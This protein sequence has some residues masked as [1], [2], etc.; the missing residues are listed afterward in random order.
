M[1]F[2]LALVS[3]L[4]CAALS[5]PALAQQ[6]PNPLIVAADV[7]PDAQ[8]FDIPYGTPIS[9]DAA[10][11]V[12]QAAVAE[13]KKRNWKMNIA[14]M[15]SGANLVAFER[16]DGAQLASITISQD[17]AR[18]AALFRRETKVFETTV[19]NGNSGVLSLGPVVASRGG[20]PLV[21]GGKLVGSIGVS[22]GTGSQDEVVAKAA[23]AALK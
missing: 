3:A 13:A 23:L 14:V 11:A 9:A 21:S 5:S 10:K 6:Q 20:I 12:L 22:G 2:K 18:A 1:N 15:D 7:V 19:L 17:K 16:M 8:G 4:A